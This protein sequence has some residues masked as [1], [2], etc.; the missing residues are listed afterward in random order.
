MT[1]IESPSTWGC[2]LKFLIRIDIED[3]RRVTLYVRVWIEITPLEEKANPGG[4]HPLREG[5]DWNL[6]QFFWTLR[7]KSHPL[8]EGV[9]WNILERCIFSSCIASPSTWGCGLKCNTDASSSVTA[10]VTLYVRVWIEMYSATAAAAYVAVTLYVRVWIEISDTAMMPLLRARHPL[11][12]GVDWNVSHYQ[13]GKTVYVV[14]LYVR[15][16]IEIPTTQGSQTSARVTL[17]VRVWIEIRHHV[18]TDWPQCGHPLREGVDWNLI[19]QTVAFGNLL[20][21]STWGCGLKYSRRHRHIRPRRLSSVWGC[22]LNLRLV[23]MFLT[24]LCGW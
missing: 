16:W 3:T 9:D 23:R 13:S 21:P 7:V 14:T 15:V 5:V 1:G 11:R 19:V 22:G 18:G 10:V 12:E 2:G 8:R 4:S 20:S 17:Y 24:I 6:I